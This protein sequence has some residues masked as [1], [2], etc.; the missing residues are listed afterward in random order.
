MQLALKSIIKETL[1]REAGNLN[2]LHYFF[3]KNF[4]KEKGKITEASAIYL[5]KPQIVWRVISGHTSRIAEQVVKKILLLKVFGIFWKFLCY[6]LQTGVV[7]RQK[8]HLGKTWW[9]NDDVTNSCQW[10]GETMEWVETGKNKQEEVSRNKEKASRT[11]Y[12]A[13]CKIGEK[14]WKDLDVVGWSEMWCV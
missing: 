10:E 7:D 6:K 12:Q 11:V 14:I 13:K 3:F 1:F 2:N 5:T 4:G 8:A 9:R